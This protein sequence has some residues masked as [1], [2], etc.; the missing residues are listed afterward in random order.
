MFIYVADPAPSTLPDNWWDTPPT[1]WPLTYLN[2]VT[3]PPPCTVNANTDSRLQAGITIDAQVEDNVLT[4][5]ALSLSMSDDS[6]VPYDSVF[7]YLKITGCEERKY[8]GGFVTWI[9]VEVPDTGKS[10]SLYFNNIITM[11]QEC[12][13]E[14]YLLG[15]GTLI[16]SASFT[17]MDNIPQALITEH[18]EYATLLMQRTI[19]APPA[20]CQ[21]MSLYLVAIQP[22]SAR[23][24]TIFTSV[25]MRAWPMLQ[26]T[27][28]PIGPGHTSSLYQPAS[29][30]LTLHR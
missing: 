3:A 4:T 6:A 13:L 12:T 21:G 10:V 11:P 22:S 27:T 25:I 30:R 5:V 8:A 2:P 18:D 28:T 9:G 15:T 24:P 17:L 20:L 7:I 19:M 1:N 16:G 23:P 26:I 14:A 29:I